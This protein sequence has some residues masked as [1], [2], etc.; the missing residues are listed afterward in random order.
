MVFN[1]KKHS[2]QI[3]DA[4]KKEAETDDTTIAQGP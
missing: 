2:H 4:N 3:E 1:V